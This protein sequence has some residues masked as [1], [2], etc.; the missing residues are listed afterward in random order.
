MCRPHIWLIALHAPEVP[1][2]FWEHSAEAWL[3]TAIKMP[4]RAAC[5]HASILPGGGSG[6]GRERGTANEGNRRSKSSVRNVR[7][8]AVP[9]ANTRARAS[10]PRPPL[11]NMLP[12]RNSALTL[13]ADHRPPRLAG[14]VRSAAAYIANGVRGSTWSKAPSLKAS[15]M[16]AIQ[17]RNKFETALGTLPVTRRS[18]CSS[19]ALLRR[20]SA[21]PRREPTIA[22]REP[23][24]AAAACCEAE[25]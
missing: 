17:E 8:R 12:T 5:L 25:P 9:R 6:R 24:R 20:S 10:S 19:E 16:A 23:T 7:R 2:K 14:R 4:S 18:W 13:E 21:P 1:I 11:F 3:A 22:S 15:V